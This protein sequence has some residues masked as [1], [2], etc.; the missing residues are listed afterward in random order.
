MVI[1]AIIHLVLNGFAMETP[2]L[3]AS[4]AADSPNRR[5]LMGEY[6]L[7][8]HLLTV[9]EHGKQAKRYTDM[10]ID[11][12][13]H[14]QNL[15]EAILN[16]KLRF[17]ASPSHSVREMGLNYLIRYFYLIVFAEFV[18]QRRGSAVGKGAA[19]ESEFSEWLQERREIPNLVA[20]PKNIGFS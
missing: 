2:P 7:I 14:I 20:K 5:Y 15:R 9:L 10:A 19:V 1:S 16:F 13:S 18:L 6:K 12:C 17:E 3:S 4:S 8:L 11:L